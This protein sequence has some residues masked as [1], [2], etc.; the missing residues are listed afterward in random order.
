MPDQRT[1][2]QGLDPEIADV[3][4]CK[5]VPGMRQVLE[6]LGYDDVEGLSLWERGVSTVGVQDACPVFEAAADAAPMRTPRGRPQDT[7]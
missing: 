5:K 1:W 6:A 3:S 2:V 7:L 4:G